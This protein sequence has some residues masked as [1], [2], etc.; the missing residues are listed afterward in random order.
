MPN[1]AVF[2]LQQPLS[3]KAWRKSDDFYKNPYYYWLALCYTITETDLF[4]VQG[5]AE[6]DYIP[7]ENWLLRKHQ[8]VLLSMV[9]TPEPPE[10]FARYVPERYET[11]NIRTRYYPSPAEKFEAFLVEE[12]DP[13]SGMSM[14]M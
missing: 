4:N 2:L 1:T 9:D 8:F 7:I 3:R 6:D 14:C 12:V 5:N 13:T 11:W 10:V